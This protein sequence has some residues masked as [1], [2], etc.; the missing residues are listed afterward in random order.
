VLQV[1]QDLNLRP[2]SEADLFILAGLELIGLDPIR[3]L[4]SLRI[5]D[6]T[7]RRSYDLKRQFKRK[8][9]L[10]WRPRCCQ[11]TKLWSPHDGCVVATLRATQR[12]QKVRMVR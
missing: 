3:H 8:L 7:Q 6:L 4:R 1:R 10:P 12:E 11:F 5:A 9:D 2:M